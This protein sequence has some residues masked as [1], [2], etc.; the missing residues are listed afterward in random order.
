MSKIFLFPLL[1]ICCTIADKQDA[2][3]NQADSLSSI[4]KELLLTLVNAQRSQGCQCGG[5][6][7][8]AVP[9]LT[10]SDKLAT[11]AQKH[12]NEMAQRN[13]LTHNSSKNGDDPG[14]RLSKAG[15]H[16]RAYAE[17]VAMGYSDERTV[18]QGWLSSPAH[19]ANIMN[20]H[21]KE[22]GVA[23]KGKYWTQV[24]GSED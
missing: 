1:F 16:W 23:H 3:E 11:V 7:Y 13:Q 4:D 12:N 18:I 8:P 5:T 9:P 21:V 15:Y 14:K 17:N 22:M 24:F 19:C 10:W 2:T 6:Y 20:P